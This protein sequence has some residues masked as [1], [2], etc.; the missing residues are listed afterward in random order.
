[1]LQGKESQSTL[2]LVAK[3]VV[4]FKR[5]KVYHLDISLNVLNL[6]WFKSIKTKAKHDKNKSDNLT[7]LRN[8]ELV[9]NNRTVLKET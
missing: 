9:E 5:D 4:K 1:M 6:N 8:T 3:V 2:H 7:K